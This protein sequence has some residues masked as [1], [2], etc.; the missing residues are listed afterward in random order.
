MLKTKCMFHVTQFLIKSLDGAD[1]LE[2]AL[3][4]NYREDGKT[5]YFTIWKHGLTEM[6]V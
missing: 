5:P 2:R 6:K 3:Y 4:L 1:P